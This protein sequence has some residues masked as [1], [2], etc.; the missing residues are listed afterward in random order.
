MKGKEGSGLRGRGEGS[1]MKGGGEG[2]TWDER[3]RDGVE[4]RGFRIRSRNFRM[5]GEGMGT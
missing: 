4:L 3:R 2:G 5:R 1:G